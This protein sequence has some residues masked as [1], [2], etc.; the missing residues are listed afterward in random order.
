MPRA[1]SFQSAATDRGP[2]AKRPR[3]ALTGEK[4][5]ETSLIE[6]VRIFHLRPMTTVLHLE[7]GDIWN[8]FGDRPRGI[9]K[10]IAVVDC[11]NH[12]R[13]R[14]QGSPGFIWDSISVV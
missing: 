3:P 2:V 9:E 8:Q 13:G 11:C 4:K 7:Y 10:Y 14:A 1:G 12:E 6:C 5:R